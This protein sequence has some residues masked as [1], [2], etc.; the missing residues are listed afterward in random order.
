M[1]AKLSRARAALLVID[2]QDKLAHA[3]PPDV[4]AHTVRNTAVLI[5]TARRMWLP[6]VVSQQYPRGLGATVSVI[7][8]ALRD[9]PELH[10]F[11]KLQFS[12]ADTPQFAALA[13]KLGRDQWI[14]VGMEAHV[15][16]Y[17]SARGLVERGYQVHVVADAIASRT[18]QNFKIGRKLIEKA[19][20]HV[21]S[22]EV[23]MFDLLG[24]AADVEFK[25]LSRL[26]K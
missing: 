7:E 11:D 23:V 10:R 14:V 26:I 21:T 4:L 1:I 18:K 2:I 8:D 13:P 25:A 24:S 5:E 9:A 19:G 20:A 16:V 3:M 6:I 12:A 22:T 17:Q 15:C